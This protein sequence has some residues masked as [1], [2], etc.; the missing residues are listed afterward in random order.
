MRARLLLAAVLLL[1]GCATHDGAVGAEQELMQTS[2]SWAQAAAGGSVEEVLSYWADDAIV[3]PPDQPAVVGK[4]AIR[5]FVQ[6][7]AAIPGF[8]I[9]WEP[10]QA[11]IA[12]S[13]DVGYLVEHNQV[14]FADSSGAIRTQF[15]KA[16]TIWRR[17]AS[18]AWKC[19]VDTWNNNPTA[20]VLAW[21]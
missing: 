11:T 14:T 20:R 19:V 9:T 10:E 7:S 17:D 18:G 3:L 5:D 15:G 8:S 13:G 4:A 6:Q 1:P 16:V 12:A 21:R 2:R